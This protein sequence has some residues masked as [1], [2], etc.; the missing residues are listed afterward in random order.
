[1][2]VATEQLVLQ[3]LIE[4]PVLVLA[5]ALFVVDPDLRRIGIV[6]GGRRCLGCVRR[7]FGL[8]RF[9]RNGL[10]HSWRGA[11]GRFVRLGY[12][13]ALELQRNVVGYR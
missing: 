8:N 3:S 4:D 5:I 2:P 6:L 11:V 12:G 9:E 7:L 10:G 1:M 13:I